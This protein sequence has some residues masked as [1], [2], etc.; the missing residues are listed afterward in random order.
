MQMLAD[1]LVRL[2]LVDTISDETIRLI[3]KKG[4]LNPGNISSG[5]F[6]R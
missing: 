5:V 2:N 6:P 4:G 3:L 1:K